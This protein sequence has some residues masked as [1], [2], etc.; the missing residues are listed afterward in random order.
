MQPEPLLVRLQHDA[1][2]VLPR[3]GRGA[4]VHRGADALRHLSGSCAELLALAPGTAIAVTAIA[5]R[6]AASAATEAPAPAAAA[7][8]TALFGLVNAEVAAVERRA[9]HLVDRLLGGLG[10]RH[11]DE[12]EAARSAALAVEHEL[13]LDHVAELRKGTMDDVLGRVEREVA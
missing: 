8:A 5:S 12:G 4:A 9:V 11:L 13:H 3:G 6:A 1:D 2:V 7:A 10:R